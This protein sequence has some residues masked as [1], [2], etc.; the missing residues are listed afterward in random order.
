MPIGIGLAVAGGAGLIGSAMQ[1]NA[2]R[3]AAQTQADA[4]ARAQNQL[5]ETGQQAS[6]QFNPYAQLGQNGINYLNQAMPSLGTG[7]TAYQPQANYMPMTNA[8]LNA[9][10]APNYA[11]QL[12][13]G[14]G[15]QNAAANVAGGMIGGNALKGLQ[16]YT[17]NFAGNAY[18]NAL[19]NYMAQYQLGLSS[20]MGQQAQAYN[21]Q[22]AN[23]T[24][25]YNRLSGIAGLGLQG[26]TGAANAMLGTG[27][28]IAQLSQGIGQAQAAG[29]VGVANAIAGGLQNAGNAGIYYGLM[30]NNQLSPYT[31]A[32]QANLQYGANNVYGF[33][34]GGTVPTN[35]DFSVDSF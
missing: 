25:I 33:G 26:A 22:T 28:N 11:F 17:Q 18:Q 12:Q 31:R 20:N 10:L 3:G 34:G 27:T 15:A 35:P 14:Q 1:A 6:Q 13:Q 9:Q 32:A 30:Q 24:N 5:L 21:Q 2:V 23:Q 4:N 8:D 7:P 29:Q 19:N 16:D